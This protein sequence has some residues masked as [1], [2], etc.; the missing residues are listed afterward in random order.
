MTINL[1]SLNSEIQINNSYLKSS[2]SNATYPYIKGKKFESIYGDNKIIPMDSYLNKHYISQMKKQDYIRQ[3]KK[4]LEIIEK[5]DNKKAFNVL[6][7]DYLKE[8][9]KISRGYYLN[10][11][12]NKKEYY[13]NLVNIDNYKEK[14]LTQNKSNNSEGDFLVSL[15][16]CLGCRPK[17]VIIRKKD[18]KIELL[19]KYKSFSQRKKQQE[20]IKEKKPVK[21]NSLQIL[22]R[23]ES[24]YNT[25]RDNNYLK[26]FNTTQNNKSNNNIAQNNILNDYDIKKSKTIF[27]K[28]NST[29]FGL[30]NYNNF[31]HPKKSLKNNDECEDNKNSFNNSKIEEIKNDKDNSFKNSNNELNNLKIKDSLGNKLYVNR[32]KSTK[33]TMKIDSSSKQ[34]IFKI[35]QNNK[36][37]IFIRNKTFMNNR[38]KNKKSFSSKF[39]KDNIQNKFLNISKDE[40]DN[41][42]DLKMIDLKIINEKLNKKH[43]KIMKQF[44]DKIKNE[45]K[46]IKENSNKLSNSIYLIKKM[47]QKNLSE[48]NFKERNK[49]ETNSKKA[50]HTER[51][52]S[53]K[54]KNHKMNHHSEIKIGNYDFLGKSKY[55]IPRVNKILFGSMENTKDNFEILQLNLQNE[56]KRQIQKSQKKG[57][58]KKIK[59]NGRDI[60][61]KL[62]VKS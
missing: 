45:E 51:N 13:T 38:R 2:S 25:E 40:E 41:P 29:T 23:L 5:L 26:Y 61:D 62:K 20:N 27:N 60:I 42:E 22:L 16:N 54:K 19:S 57:L 14:L 9:L 12:N 21:R 10:Q 55:S 47:N 15:M 32:K 36:N 35:N 56:V 44:L 39:W 7:D 49:T 3:E 52:E 1:S 18:K 24:L 33:K 59:L 50:Y 53:K 17:K 28:T 6:K 8:R 31:Y 58:S 46:S 11:K 37:N 30:T 4:I 34:N 48:I 43:V